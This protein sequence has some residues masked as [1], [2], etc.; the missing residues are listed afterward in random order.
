MTRADYEEIKLEIVQLQLLE[1]I[2][3]LRWALDQAPSRIDH[4]LNQSRKFLRKAKIL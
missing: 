1:A 2:D 4:Y 3:K